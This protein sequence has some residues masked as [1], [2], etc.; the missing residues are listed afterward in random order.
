MK[1]IFVTSMLLSPLS[2]F[3]ENEE[4]LNNILLQLKDAN[5]LHRITVYMITF[6]SG[7]CLFMAYRQ[8]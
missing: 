1:K 8:R 6:V 4:V 2:L 3:A 7:V 5:D